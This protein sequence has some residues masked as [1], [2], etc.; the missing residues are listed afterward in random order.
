M[1]FSLYPIERQ[2]KL[3]KLQFC[4][5]SLGAMGWYIERG[6]TRKHWPPARGPPLRTGSTD[7]LRTGPRTTPAD[8]ST[9]YPPN[10]VKNKNND[11]NYYLSNSS[12]APAK[13]RAL[14]WENVTDRGS[15]SGASYII[16]HF[17]SSFAVAIGTYERLGNHREATKFVLLWVDFLRH[18]IRP[19]LPRVRER[20]PGFMICLTEFQ[21]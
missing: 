12:L 9:D 14:R 20:V 21:I 17:H 10:N 2:K 6:V 4:P 19:I 18:F 3:K 5:E 7:Y 8:P 11:F 15:V 1:L 13:F 16:S